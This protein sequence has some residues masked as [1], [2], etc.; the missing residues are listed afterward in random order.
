MP[1]TCPT[2][3]GPLRPTL[4]GATGARAPGDPLPE[5]RPGLACDNCQVKYFEHDG[6]LVRAGPEDDEA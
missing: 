5:G 6:E 4:V 1:L 2:C 3:S